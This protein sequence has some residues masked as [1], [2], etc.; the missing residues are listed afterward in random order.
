[1]SQDR[2]TGHREPPTPDT[3]ADESVGPAQPIRPA[4]GEPEAPSPAPPGEHVGRAQPIDPERRQGG[5]A[6]DTGADPS[7]RE[8][9]PAPPAPE[10]EDEPAARPPPGR[11]SPTRAPTSRRTRAATARGAVD[12]VRQA[13]FPVVL[14]GY[15]RAAVDAY[16]AEVAQLVAELEATQLPET[17]VQ[18]ALDEVGGETSAILKRAHEAGAEI[19]SRSRSQAE[20]RL[21]RAEREAELTRKE[22]EDQVRRLEDDIQNVWQER[23]RLIEDIRTLADDVLALADDAMERMPAPDEQDEDRGR[24]G[25]AGAG[26]PGPPGPLVADVDAGGGDEDA[27][28]TG[29]A[30][31]GLATEPPTGEARADDTIVDAPPDESP[32]VAED[33]TLEEGSEDEDTAERPPG[34]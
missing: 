22:T 17:V 28:A 4:G 12:R 21:Q 19:T 34:S 29:P 8:V 33:M 9:S 6:R 18:R 27:A 16:V 10:A 20:S 13:D 26:G 14:R 23:Q 11:Q 31:L 32:G 3:G 5:A 2:P 7:E 1:M 30:P 15:D 24:P 25:R